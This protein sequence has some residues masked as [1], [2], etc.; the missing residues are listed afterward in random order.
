MV[1]PNILLVIT[2]QNG[3]S[4]QNIKKHADL[5]FIIKQIQIIEYLQTTKNVVRNFLSH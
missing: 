4:F 3:L 2:S 1:T 5:T